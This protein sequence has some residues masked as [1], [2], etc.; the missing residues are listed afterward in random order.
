MSLSISMCLIQTRRR[1]V[2]RESSPSHVWQFCQH[3][4]NTL[5]GSFEENGDVNRNQVHVKVTS[6]SC[7]PLIRRPQ[8]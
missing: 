7:G 5:S 6:S 1:P 2:V 3:P 4:L 8:S